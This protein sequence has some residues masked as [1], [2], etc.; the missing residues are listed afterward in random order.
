MPRLLCFVRTAACLL[1]A[2]L[3][4]AAE[5]SGTPAQ[6]STAQAELAPLFRS[7]LD[8]YNQLLRTDNGLYRDGWALDRD[9]TSRDLCS[10]ATTGVGL[11]ALCMNHELGRDPAAAQKA[12]QTLQAINGKT[13]D[14]R[15]GREKA[16]YFRHFFSSRGRP[17]ASEFSTID[18]A[19]MV[20]GALYCRNTFDDP[21]IKAEADQL[22]NSIDW[23]V[24]LATPKGER[25]HMTIADGKP[26]AGNPTYLFNEYFVLAWLIREA[27]LQKTGHSEVITLG[28]LPTWDNHGLKLL[29]SNG[30]W[31]QCSFIIQ[32]PFY[33]SHPGVTDG[34]YRDFVLA[35]AQADQRECARRFG[36]AEYWGCGA[37]RGVDGRYK[38]SHY[39]KNPQNIVAPHIIAGFMPAFPLAQEHLRALYRDPQRRVATPVGDILPRF[40]VDNPAWHPSHVEA[41]DYSSMLFGLAAIDPRLGPKFFEQ[42]TR[43]TFNR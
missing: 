31:P 30:P 42:K 28:D 25:L 39:L 29:C 12:L 13:P 7:T 17:T 4:A 9:N 21:R 11:M 27:Q 15:I 23:N 38:A 18:T 33:M 1:G 35:Q 8:F 36:H 40:C 16:G 10:S 19:I 37:G 32:F 43:F 20:V 34:A 14:F 2:C 5:K 22:W 6:P 41:I 24:A 3:L 26:G